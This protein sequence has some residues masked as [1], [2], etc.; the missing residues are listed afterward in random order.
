MAMTSS[1]PSRRARIAGTLLRYRL[2]IVA[3]AAAA[4]GVWDAST[5][6]SAG[7]GTLFAR[8][9]ERLFSG[10]WSHALAD[11]SIQV[12]PLH[13][14]FSGV[15]ASVARLIHVSDKVALS[16]TVET[17]SSVALALLLRALWG[18][19]STRHQV[20]EIAA[21]CLWILWLG[22]VATA[23]GQSAETLV[24]LMWLGAAIAA[25]RGKG[26]GAGLLLGASA[27]MKGWGILGLPILVLDDDHRDAVLGAVVAVGSMALSY[28]PFL[29]WGSVAS[30]SYHWTVSA[31]APLHYVLGAGSDFS[32][33][34]R[35]LQGALVL[36]G[37]GAAA[38]FGRKS[39]AA[40]WAV[41]L[42]LV[43]LRVLVDPVYYWYYWVPAQTLGLVGIASLLLRA[44]SVRQYAATAFLY[45]TLFLSTDH[46]PLVG[47]GCL[48]VV[49]WALLASDQ[50]PEAL[51]F[52][53]EVV[54]SGRAS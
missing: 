36:G 23:I 29:I 52:P 3:V 8:A 47:V 51:K 50:A 20:A 6:A 2:L 25:R 10:A 13:L 5:A 33:G 54:A 26:I 37:G 4:H 43:V 32:W 22:G 34:A 30:F 16:V 38:W 24:P 18:R 1:A 21:C 17:V 14:A 42:V 40:V 19:A 45:G 41:P 12:G 11:P 53:V 39:P 48:G 46:P 15:V 27:A 35:L 31:V 44:R 9:G 7:D 28:A 49:L